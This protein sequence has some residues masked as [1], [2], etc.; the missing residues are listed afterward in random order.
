MIRAKQSAGGSWLLRVPHPLRAGGRIRLCG[1]TRHEVEGRAARLAAVGVDLRLGVL[2]PAQAWAAVERL[3]GRAATV[4]VLALWAPYVQSLRP[5]W[6]RKARGV[7]KQR[8]CEFGPLSPWELTAARLTG[9]QACEVAA[10]CSAKTVTNAFACLRAAFRRDPAFAG[11]GLPWGL[12]QPG[13]VPAAEREACRDVSEVL[14]LIEAA[15]QIDRAHALAIGEVRDL[16]ARVA[17]LA[18]CGLR[19][20]EAAALGWDAVELDAAAPFIRIFRAT[21]A[22]WSGVR[23]D[24][25]PKGRRGRVQL[26]HPDAVI[27]LRAQAAALARLGWL[28]VDGPVFPAAGG[29]WRPSACVV[30]SDLFR[31]VVALAGLPNVPAWCTHSL[32]HTF[33]SL[34]AAAAFAAGGDLAGAMA[35]TGHARAATLTGYLHASGRGL[36][37]SGIGRLSGGS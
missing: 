13:R 24:D 23:P 31:R 25:L 17:V 21:V 34:E 22:G 18:L 19:Q 11:A 7:W 4:T 8:L 37:P 10:G 15:A 33:A 9:W 28:R 1:V 30:R 14:R 16:P 29:G 27:A 35:R 12:W 26:L 2:A 5:S 3:T 36:A 20:G 32:R 6:A